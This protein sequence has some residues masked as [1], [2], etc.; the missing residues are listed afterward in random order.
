MK[1]YAFCAFIMDFFRFCTAD[2]VTLNFWGSSKEFN[3][4]VTIKPATI[5][6]DW[7]IQV[8]FDKDVTVENVSL[9]SSYS[10]YATMFRELTN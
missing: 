8:T 1:L 7:R 6:N 10:V 9:I 5:I 4:L 3:A 2:C